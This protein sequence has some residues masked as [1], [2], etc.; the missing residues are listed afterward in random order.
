[1]MDY[2]RD[3]ARE[4]GYFLVKMGAFDNL[5]NT[6]SRICN[7]SVSDGSYAINVCQ[8]VAFLQA[9]RTYELAYQGRITLL[10]KITGRMRFLLEKETSEALLS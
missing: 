10:K 7:I 9:A 4:I 1:M 6:V 2:E 3:Q 8:N 5:G